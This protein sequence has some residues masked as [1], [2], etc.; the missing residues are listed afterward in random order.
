[1][2]CRTGPCRHATPTGT[3]AP[4]PPVK[5]VTMTRTSARQTTVAA[6]PGIGHV[7]TFECLHLPLALSARFTVHASDVSSFEALRHG[8][9]VT[10]VA[11]LGQMS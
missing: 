10:A 9:F 1:M 3:M 2:S 8:H 11:M 5:G 4:R 7:A 6:G